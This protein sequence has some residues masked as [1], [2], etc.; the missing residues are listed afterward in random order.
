METTSKQIKIDVLCNKI[1]T[2]LEIGMNLDEGF[3][4]KVHMHNY[5][6]IISELFSQLEIEIGGVLK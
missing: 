4:S 6:W 1:N 2:L 3:N 5:I